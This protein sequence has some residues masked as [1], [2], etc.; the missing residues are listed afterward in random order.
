[1]KIRFSVYA[2]IGGQQ[3]WLY[4]NKGNSYYRPSGSPFAYGKDGVTCYDYGGG[5]MKCK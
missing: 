3:G 4:D 5:V 2:L 1:M